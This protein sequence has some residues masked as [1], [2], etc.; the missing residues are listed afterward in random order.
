MAKQVGSLPSLIQ[1][2]SQQEPHNRAPGKMWESINMIDSLTKGKVRR[3]G[4]EYADH[5]QLPAVSAPA[6]LEAVD[7]RE[8]TFF[9][10]GREYSLVYRTNPSTTG[11]AYFAKLVSKAD[12]KF[13]NIVYEDSSW[14]D[15]LILGGV[16]AVVCIGRY[17]YLAGN[18]TLP[19][20]TSTDV[21]NLPLNMQKLSGWVREGAYSRTFTVTVYRADNT[22]L[23]ATYKTKSAAYPELLDTTDIP[24]YLPGGTEPDPEY[25]KKL[26]DRVNAY[27]GLKTAWIREAA[28][29]IV[30]AN[31]A[32]KLAEALQ[33]LSVAATSMG[34]CVLVDDPE[35]VD[36]RMA[37]DGNNSLVSAVGKE[38]TD[39]SE[40]TLYHWHGKVVRVRPSSGG[41][42]ES[43]YLKAIGLDGATGWAKV[44]W[45][46][47]AGVE[48]KINTMLSQMVIDVAGQTAYVAADGLGL[49]TLAP[50]L[51]D[52][53]VYKGNLV[54]DGI[55]AP[56]PHFFG[57]KI[58]GLAVFQDRLLVMSDNLVSM[59]RTS[60]YLN[61]FRQTVLNILDTDPVEIFAHGSEGDTIKRAVMYERDLVL[62]GDLRQYAISGREF[63]TAAA[64]NITIIGA[65]EGGTRAQPIASGNF[66]FFAKSANQR[67]GLH[68]M[69]PGGTPQTTVVH[70]MAQ[71]LDEWL[72]GEPVQLLG[73][74][75]P[76]MVTF[77]TTAS[78]SIWY[79]YRYAD[80]QGAGRILDSWGKLSYDPSLGSVAGITHHNGDLL[81]VTLRS[82]GGSDYWFLDRLDSGV[83][84]S[85]YPHLDSQ[86]AYGSETPWHLAQTD[87][88]AAVRKGSEYYMMGTPLSKVASF[89]EQAPGVED[90]LVVGTN[91]PASFQLTNP[92]VRDGNG[93]AVLS[94]R[95][96]ITQY[97]LKLADTGGMRAFV[98][99]PLPERTLL[100]EG[101]VL[102][103]SNNIA[104]RQ[105]IYSGTRS[106][107]VG[108]ETGSC[109]V[110]IRSDGWLPMRVTGA[111]WS[112]LSFMPRARGLY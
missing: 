11:K 14:I 62:F 71:E 2:V 35:F 78:P 79:V 95:L 106:V 3:R 59:S 8:Y 57:R 85:D 27:E 43:Y 84:L 88:T 5:E 52:H 111:E 91:T 93:Q 28:E 45:V 77:R 33:D 40:A 66:L 90:H 23:S 50:Q 76:N 103:N 58:S 17:V 100:F 36:I 87:L 82:A 86:V 4:T 92:Y 102:G 16:S 101:R 73:T 31:V 41:D 18:T 69:Q 1:G 7:M 83:T 98:L 13:Y 47:A 34:P 94:A 39:P 89:I 32:L 65:Y 54:G 10:D 104:G 97:N 109:V 49:K 9:V 63:M 37:D 44:E 99:G 51:G 55:T 46:E 25:Q 53:P 42:S 20:A 68:Q 19:N 48:H 12:N 110:E 112:G 6:L 74:T 38:I 105:P 22:T 15:N 72:A 26:A 75:D 70:D 61:F 96:T 64:P 56:L 60:D 24:F 29:D 81:I 21:W 80:Q 107:S 67:T 30:P 108:R